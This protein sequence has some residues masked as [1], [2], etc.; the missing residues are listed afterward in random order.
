MT[1]EELV[2]K[3]NKEIKEISFDTGVSIMTLYRL[4]A[5][6]DP[7]IDTCRKLNKAGITVS[8]KN[9]KVEYNF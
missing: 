1:F 6:D 2:K 5:G 3:M 8:I 7:S 4:Y 9:E